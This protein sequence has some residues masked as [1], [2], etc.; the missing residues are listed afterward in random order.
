MKGASTAEHRTTDEDTRVKGS[1]QCRSSEPARPSKTRAGCRG[2]APRG[3]LAAVRAVRA[4]CVRPVHH[5]VLLR[6]GVIR[7]HRRLVAS[8]SAVEQLR[9]ACGVKEPHSGSFGRRGI[10]P[11][12]TGQPQSRWYRLGA[13]W[14]GGMRGCHRTVAEAPSG[15]PVD[16]RRV[17]GGKRRWRC[18]AWL[19]GYPSATCLVRGML[20]LPCRVVL[21]RGRGCGGSAGRARPH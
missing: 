6:R 8:P 21:R 20:K 9:P 2:A 18:T 12:S 16:P 11:P 19:A 17:T 4:S 1:F 10:G 14:C 13:M 3:G 5:T 15:E 7:Y